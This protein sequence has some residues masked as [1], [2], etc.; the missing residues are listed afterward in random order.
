MKQYSFIEYSLVCAKH[1]F[2]PTIHFSS[3]T[4][5]LG[6]NILTQPFPKNRDRPG[7]LRSLKGSIY[8]RGMY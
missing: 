3:V 2:I 6:Y 8:L 5:F 4:V 1:I 7:Y